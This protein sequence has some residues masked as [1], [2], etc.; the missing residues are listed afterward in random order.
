M[1]II[2]L[3]TALLR[4][5]ASSGSSVLSQLATLAGCVLFAFPT[6][7]A[8][9]ADYT[10]SPV[11]S[12]LNP[13]VG[14]TA[15]LTGSGDTLTNGSFT[16]VVYKS[17]GTTF[18]SAGA[19]RLCDKSGTAGCGAYGP[20]TSYGVGA[21]T[22]NVSNGFTHTGSKTYFLQRVSTTGVL[23]ANFKSGEFIVTRYVPPPDTTPPNVSVPSASAPLG[24]IINGTF[25][26]S[27]A[28]NMP[29]V[30]VQLSRSGIFPNTGFA[31]CLVNASPVS[32]TVAGGSGTYSYTASNV[33]CPGLTGVLNQVIYYHS[34]AQDAAG[35]S[36]YSGSSFV[37]D[38]GNQPPALSSASA[39]RNAD[40]SVSSSVFAS[41]IDQ[42]SF[43]IAAYINSGGNAV[44]A[45][46]K[47]QI[48]DCTNLNLSNGS[49]AFSWTASEMATYAAGG[50]TFTVQF[51]ATDSQGNS[52]STLSNTFTVPAPF[53]VSG[54]TPLTGVVS[55]VAP[56]TVTGAGF[57]SSMRISLSNQSGA[58]CAAPFTVAATSASFNCTLD[59]VGSQ[60][61]SVRQSVPGLSVRDFTFT[62]TA[63]APAAT[64]TGVSP[65]AARLDVPQIFTVAG[66]GLTTGMGFTVA[67]CD[68]FS[69]I[70]TGGSASSRQYQCTP[71]LPGRKGVI[72]K[73]APGGTVIDATRFVTVDHP[74]R[75]GD[76]SARGTP[77][78]GG[79]SLFNGNFFSQ[80]V[81]LSVPGK[82]LS[83][84]LT[85]SYNSYDWQY[86]TD[87]GGV[88]AARPWRFNIEMKIGYVPNTGNLRLFV[89]REDGSGES[90][91][92]SAGTWYPIDLGNYSTIK[93]N[94]DGTYTVQSRGQ[95]S[96]TFEP[97]SGAGRL[98]RTND[99]DGNQITYAYATS[100]NGNGKVVQ[101]NDSSG[102]LYAVTYDAQ[103]RISRVTDFTGRYVEYTYTDATTTNAR[104]YQ[105]RDVRGGLT[106]YN[107][108]GSGDLISVVDPRL[109]TALTLT[110]TTVYGNTG[111]QSLTT[112][113]GR[114][115]G[116]RT[117]NGSTNFTYCF[118][119]TQLPA[120]VGFRTVV[121]GPE[122]AT[123]SSVDFDNAGRATTIA[124]GQGNA[125]ATTFEV[126]DESTN[127]AKSALANVR[128]TALGIAGGYQTSIANNLTHGIVNS[129][130]NAAL[131]TSST[132]WNIDAANNLFTP[133]TVTTPLTNVS[134]IGYTTTGRPNRITAARQFA[135]SGAAAPSTSLTWTNGVLTGITDPLNQV[136]ALTRDTH[137]NLTETT[138]PRNATWKTVRTYDSLGR[139]L[140][141]TDARGGVT[142][143]T[144]DE[145]GNMRTSTQEIPSLPSVV[146][147]YTYDANGNL[148]T[149]IDPLLTQTTYSYDIGNRISAISR[150]VS[151][152]T[153]TRTMGYDNASRLVSVT[154][155]NN[156]TSTRSF[157]AA[158]RVIAEALPLSRTTSYTYDA[159]NRLKTATD[160]EGRIVSYV[161]D[162]VGRVT[163]VTRVANATNLTQSYEYDT[164]GR[165]TLFR[166][167]KGNPTN[168]GYDRNG[169]LTSVQDANG[170]TSTAIYD[171]ANRMTSRTDPRIK[172]TSYEYDATG[173][174]TA[175]IDPL[176][177]RWQ[178]TYDQNSN[179]T[180]VLNPSVSGVAGRIITHTYDALNRRVRTNYSDGTQ[181]T[182]TYDA[183]G[184]L[185]SMIDSVGTT[186]YLHDEANRLKQFTDPFGNVV[187]YTFDKAGNRKTMTY[188]GSRVVTYGYDAAE[189]M[190]SVLDW[191]NRTATYTYNLADQITKLV[192]GNG[193]TADYNYDTAG[194]LTSLINKQQNGTVISSH[195]NTLDAFGNITQA[196]EVLPL[197]PTLTPRIKRWT[198][199]DANRVLS[200]SVSGDSFEHDAAG[201]LIRQIVNGA[202]TNFSHNDIDLLTTL[203]GAGR[204]ESYRYN[205]H[206]HRMERVANGLT[207]RF[208]VEPD[209]DSPNVVAE[210]DG[211]NSPKRFNVYGADGLLAQID[212]TSGFRAYHFA[213]IGH[214]VALS[215]GTGAVSDKYAYLPYGEITRDPANATV[216]AFTFMGEEGV[217][218]DGGDMMYARARYLHRGTN[219][220]TS[221]DPVNAAVPSAQANQAYAYAES[222]PLIWNDPSGAAFNWK[223]GAKAVGESWNAART[224]LG[225]QL[226]F[227]GEFGANVVKVTTH[228]IAAVGHEVF[229]APV[230]EAISNAKTTYSEVKSA[231]GVLAKGGILVFG[232]LATGGAIVSGV[233]FP[234]ANAVK[235]GSN[236]IVDELA[237]SKVVSES[238][239]KTTKQVIAV[240]T[241]IKSLVGDSA[242]FVS[243]SSTIVE[244][245]KTLDFPKKSSI[246][247]DAINDFGK[248]SFDALKS[249]IDYGTEVAKA[250]KEN[251]VKAP[252]SKK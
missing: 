165:L 190:N 148:A 223:R 156:N 247:R 1:Q 144:Y 199:D 29:T 58:N 74:A 149:H 211:S 12:A 202:T 18:S 143:Y 129:V 171:D 216:N 89:S 125:S 31:T 99:R 198:V 162:R 127:Y 113:V 163:S 200:N 98:L 39:T 88:P 248:S 152:V 19:V 205:G 79:V 227:V 134:G 63:A 102:R 132:A 175:E 157:D 229:V 91:F 2:F 221:S 137:G 201:R 11:R 251:Q 218:D 172:T 242:K 21:G 56:V 178:Y 90:Y 145:A 103:A 188:P 108:N 72:V 81:D 187:S 177:D 130:T 126:I 73:T 115:T 10:V 210:L 228:T 136:I 93:V 131:E 238:V 34:Y 23:D 189:R 236:Q 219:R 232:T 191:T 17:D 237:K 186:T 128:K 47:C 142:R 230:A 240:G 105:F 25:T 82:G 53:S 77:S 92:V 112:A 184:N 235:G 169:N 164:E 135:V 86:E 97:P 168:Y 71:R 78:V 45:S 151:G 147:T 75:L 106:T 138:D 5:A 182:Y 252:R 8:Y 246:Y 14:F 3:L 84:A 109:N 69:E 139:V 158:G 118:T 16:F 52:S 67:D 121:D 140:S 233:T 224:E 203:V 166:D 122:N 206:G 27:D 180:G 9:A 117:C 212:A 76:P 7:S 195:T 208:L 185:V 54:A 155:E 214:T 36:A 150:V 222:N 46:R 44:T 116:G 107:Y 181:V 68:N 94:G 43:G 61:L 239:G 51:I 153:T 24:G 4:G 243:N 15:Y 38:P 176:N 217:V 225:S 20:D 70:T 161:Y 220:F 101:V 114:A 215:D 159:D 194:R 110:Y 174:L 100:G 250:R 50:G 141:V 123:I 241:A 49:Y 41:D 124:D 111:V 154:N 33:Q 42:N 80:S 146:N 32:P 173:N 119:Y 48:A 197:Q 65:P 245:L 60:T 104:I 167:A 85:R 57:T 209:G 37:I 160:P 35:N 6:L 204:N 120:S 40:G 213:P 59:T 64:V 28:N 207:T 244:K 179:L 22:I 30:A 183:N 26:A 55:T 192:H 234:I 193:A 95:L 96:H 62:V 226:Q 87:H 133:A 83:F 196:N 170:V 231:N 66:T 249:T 13:G